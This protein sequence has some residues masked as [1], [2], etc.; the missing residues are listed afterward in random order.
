MA[1]VAALS[2]ATMEPD[3]EGGS[4]EELLPHE[5]QRWHSHLGV[6]IAVLVAGALTTWGVVTAV[7]LPRGSTSGAVAADVVSAARPV[8][9]RQLLEGPELADVVSENFMNLGHGYLSPAQRGEVRAAV[10][11]NLANISGSLRARVP[12]D[13]AKLG[14]IQLSHEQRHSVLRVL[15]HYS[16]PRVLRLG[17]DI[18]EAVAETKAEAGDRRSLHRRLAA[19]LRPRLRELRELCDDIAPGSGKDFNFDFDDSDD[20]EP[21]QTSDKWHLKVEMTP[22]KPM[23]RGPATGLT[24]RR[25]S[26]TDTLSGTR[27][28]A[29]LVL[30]HLEGMLGKTMPR[31]PARMLLFDQQKQQSSSGMEQ[32][33]SCVMENMSNLPEMFQCLMTNCKKAM[34]YL[35]QKLHLG[36]MMEKMMPTS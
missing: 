15:R 36:E 4:A 33:A 19:K 25:L 1:R 27:D 5:E 17:G 18:A 28:Q 32:V 14:L 24:A 30:R 23:H 35:M 8:T 7:A 9:V 21:V 6:V 10:A 16:D 22:P 29:T 13:H 26:A 34:S 11:D 3:E 12:A 31:A 20:L 2:L